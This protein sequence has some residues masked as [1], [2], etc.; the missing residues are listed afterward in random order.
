MGSF[1]RLWEGKTKVVMRSMKLSRRFLVT[2]NGPLNLGTTTGM[3]DG[4]VK[5]YALMQDF[6]RDGG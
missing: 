2:W 5:A 1:L 4:C 6:L 3:T